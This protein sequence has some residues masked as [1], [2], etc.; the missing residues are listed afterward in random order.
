M[1][2]RPVKSTDALAICGIYNYYI[3]NT[4]ISFEEAPVSPV[5]MEIRI[6]DVAAQYPWFVWEEAG[7]VLAYAYINT[8]KNRAAYRYAAELSI[9]VQH[10]K[11]GCGM[12]GKLMAHLLDAV[13]KMDIH[14]LVSGITLPNERSIVLHE[15]FGFRKTA[16]FNEI[17]FKLDRWQHVGYW[18]LVVNREG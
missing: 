1:M 4:A 2:I 3:C 7:E 6:R 14:V 8:W 17:G 15:K 9:Y 10:G 11:E 5:E 18:Q 12:G 16:Q 13:K